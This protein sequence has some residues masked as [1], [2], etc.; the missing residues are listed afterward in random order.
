VKA[1]VIC[2]ALLGAPIYQQ[3]GL[4]SH[5]SVLALS[6]PQESTTAANPRLLEAGD[7]GAWAKYLPPVAE[8]R[9]VDDAPPIHRSSRFPVVHTCSAGTADPNGGAP[10]CSVDAADP[11]G[12]TCSTG[13]G[14]NNVCSAK[15]SNPAGDGLFCSVDWTP[16]AK[17]SV[18]AKGGQMN[19]CS[20]Q[21]AADTRCSVDMFGLCS[22]TKSAPPGPDLTNKC[23]AFTSP[24]GNSKAKCSAFNPNPT[25]TDAFC[26]ITSTADEPATNAICTVLQETPDDPAGGPMC[27]AFSMDAEPHGAGQKTCSAMIG[28]T[29]YP[30]EAWPDGICRSVVPGND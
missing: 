17:C 5:T 25:S 8:L 26:S 24:D 10:K 28:G 7:V 15:G 30:P 11:N 4:F 14:G 16:V 22:V 9:P 20:A 12:S 23:T 27:S 18:V 21:G 19:Y 2:G 1:I 6:I 3:L 29:F 13:G